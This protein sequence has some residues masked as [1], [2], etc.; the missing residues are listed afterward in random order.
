MALNG[1][2]SNAISS[3]FGG[4]FGGSGADGTNKVYLRSL[5]G[6]KTIQDE[7]TKVYSFDLLPQS[8]SIYPKDFDAKDKV[9][10]HLD[11]WNSDETL[12]INGVDVKASDREQITYTDT[13]ALIISVINT[14]ITIVTAALVSF[15]SLSLVVSCFMIAVIT[16]I[17]VMERVKEIG[18]IRSLGGRKKDVNRLFTAEN[19]MT[20]L[21]SGVIGIVATYLLSGVINIV[22]HFFGV[23]AIAALP[24][25]MAL[26]M[27]G[28]SI[29]LNVISGFI[30]SRK[31]A[32]QDPVVALRT[33]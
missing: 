11:R 7:E 33:E 4:M 25:W 26:I 5:C 2:L 28:L 10:E 15:T 31:A 1:D 23:P 17:S 3:M 19:F 32:K 21:A 27:I 22:V 30:P 29:F 12:H 18:V 8:V 24:W 16:Y 14:L 6:L 13:V 9:T 20:G